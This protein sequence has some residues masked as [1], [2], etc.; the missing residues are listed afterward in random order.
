MKSS[1]IAFFACLTLVNAS[2]LT[3]VLGAH[4]RACYYIQTTKPNTNIAY[5]FA[6]QSGGDFDVDYTVRS[7]KNVFIVD[8]KKVRQ[9]DWI[10]NG[11]DAGEYE[12]CFFNGAASY[13]E[14]VLDFELKLENDF[15]AAIPL[16]QD[17]PIAVEGMQDTITK[18]GFKLDDLL[19][20]LYYYKARTNRNEATVKST[21]SRIFWFSFL[22]VVLMVGMGVLQVV[23]VQLFFKGSRKQLV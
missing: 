8:E 12:F 13:V 4:D 9:G 21:E 6:V 19:K 1:I 23:I 10:F 16:S 22:E 2:A 3:F 20:S 14:K 17:S 18:I 5:Y 11:D 7:P 15:R